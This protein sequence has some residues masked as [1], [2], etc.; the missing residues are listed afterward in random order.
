MCNGLKMA[1]LLG[2]ESVYSLPDSGCCDY[3]AKDYGASDAALVSRARSCAAG[4]CDFLFLEQ[5]DWEK[6][7]AMPGYSETSML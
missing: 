6:P 1:V 5:S 4:S 7:G 2:G 3:F